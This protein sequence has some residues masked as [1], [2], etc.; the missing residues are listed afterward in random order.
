MGIALF[1]LGGT[2]SMA[3]HTQ[4]IGGVIRLNGADL[5]AAVPGLT[6]LGM[7]LDIHDM[8]A[9]PSANLTFAHVLAL[10][11]SAS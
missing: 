8:D 5:A 10:A 4:G 2:I 11:D 7:P 3:G 1:T 9:V 6:Q